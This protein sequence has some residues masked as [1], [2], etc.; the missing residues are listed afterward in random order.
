VSALVDTYI[1]RWA[2]TWTSAF[3][4]LALIALI[5]YAIV[6]FVSVAVVNERDTKT[7]QL[8]GELANFLLAAKDEDGRNL[9]ENP[10]DF[11]RAQREASPVRLPRSFFRF[12]LTRETART[13]RAEEI[14]WEPP[15]ACVTQ[16]PLQKGQARSAGFGLES[17]FAIVPSDT[18]GR[19]VYFSLK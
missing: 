5:I 8:S 6:D 18:E 16:F 10:E 2:F 14:A 3:A 13:L 12:F 17:C 1:R 9:L 7:A 19:F 4:G 15:S 11:S